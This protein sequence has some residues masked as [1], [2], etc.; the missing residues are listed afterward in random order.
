MKVRHWAAALIREPLL[1]FM[2]LGVALFA[3]DR[4]ALANADNP[5]RI[6]VDDA[7]YAEIAAA[8]E[9]AQ[10]RAPSAEE[11]QDLI[12]KWS[13]NEVLYREARQMGL[14]RGDD[15][16]RQRLLLKLRNIL[17]SNI[18]TEPPSEQDLEAWF[19]ARRASYDR[20]PRF[21]FEQFEVS[22]DEASA[23]A[24]AAKL[25]S[26]PTPDEYADRVRRYYARPASNITSVLGEEAARHLMAEGDQRWAVV[27]SAEKWH[28]SRIT[29]RYPAEPVSF[30][31]ARSRILTEYT[32]A[33]K[34][35]ELAKALE[36]IVEQYD[37]RVIRGQK[38]PEA[39]PPKSAALPAF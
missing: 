17:F 38:P 26:G 15:M 18:V 14:D 27:R 33:A 35:A 34:R 4:Y 5:R 37:I 13:Q 10:G 36:G 23:R 11:A 19:E 30:A 29:R 21:D 9:E 8:F 16:I 6:V 28:L 32:E 2:V 39:E 22:S 12:L 24:L 7:K 1:Q 3:I 25:G 20:P 31:E